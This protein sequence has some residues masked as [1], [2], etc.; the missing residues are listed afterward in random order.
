[1]SMFSRQAYQQG[2]L[3]KVKRARGPAV[4]E[5]RYRDNSAQGRPQRQITL[6]TVDFPTEAT[7]RRHL[8]ALVWKLNSGTSQNV[9][10]RLTFGALCDLFTIDEHLEEIATLKSGEANTFGGLR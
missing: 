7:A 8:E 9:T 2:S 4:W 3:R 1:M 6:S 5:F 10:Q